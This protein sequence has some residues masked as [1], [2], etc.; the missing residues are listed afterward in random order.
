MGVGR[1]QDLSSVKKIEQERDGYLKEDEQQKKNTYDYVSHGS[2]YPSDSRK[3]KVCHLDL[4]SCKEIVRVASLGVVFEKVRVI[5]LMN[6][7]W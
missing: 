7:V 3:K 2:S 1:A 5:L 4:H 6:F